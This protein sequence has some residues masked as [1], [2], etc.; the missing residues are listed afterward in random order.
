LRH[1]A[2]FA[3]AILLPTT[4]LADDDAVVRGVVRQ[5][6]VALLNPMGMEHTLEVGARA[7]IGD[8][9]ELLFMG[10]H[11]ETGVVSYV[12]P[13]YAIHGAYVQVSPLAFLVLRAELTHSQLWP[14]GMSGAGYYG[15]SAY[16]D[17]VSPAA[18]NAERGA[19]AT[20]WS[21]RAYATLQ[22]LVPLGPVR[23]LIQDQL[24]VQSASLGEASHYYDMKWDLVLARQDLVLITGAVLLLEVDLEATTHLRLGAYDDVRVV[25]SSGYLGHQVGPLVMLTLDRLAPEVPSLSVFVR[26]GYYTHHV[27]RADQLTIL[28]GVAIDYDL[29]TI[30]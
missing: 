30:R 15:L 9:H 7:R 17:D 2:I 20:G 4:A 8:P 19:T 5:R 12:S 14:L 11:A 13:V 26:G 21:A 27:L 18:L 24:I 23:L 3:L 29:G 25:P 28:G 16:D 6:F 22:G 10:A 1:A